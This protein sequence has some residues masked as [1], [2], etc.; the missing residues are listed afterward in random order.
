MDTE[1]LYRRGLALRRRI[2]GDA[3]VERRMNAFGDFGAPLQSLINGVAY[4]DIWSRDG[5]SPKMRSLVVIGINA[6]LDHPQELRVHVQGALANGCTADEI[7]EILLLIAVYCGIPAAN[8]AHR[9]AYE[10]L[11]EKGLA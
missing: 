8:E 5:I 1:E 3:A 6:A 9:V 4:G 7:R 2:F 11:H 10:V